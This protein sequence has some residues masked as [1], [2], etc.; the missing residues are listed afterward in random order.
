MRNEEPVNLVM[1]VLGVAV[2]ANDPASVVLSSRRISHKKI[3]RIR[4]VAQMFRTRRG[5]VRRRRAVGANLERR[6]NGCGGDA[7]QPQ[8]DWAAGGVGVV[9]G[10]ESRN[11]PDLEPRRRHRASQ[12]WR[13]RAEFGDVGCTAAKIAGIYAVD[14]VGR[15]STGSAG[16]SQ[17]S[18]RGDDPKACREVPCEMRRQLR[19]WK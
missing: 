14:S 13:A 11:W 15:T 18:C 1:L 10:V 9:N 16:G 8:R 3:A 17:F 6:I 7:E 2:L 12:V 5:L 4:L 19:F